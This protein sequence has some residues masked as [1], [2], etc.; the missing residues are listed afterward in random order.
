MSVPT[1][2]RIGP[3]Y[4]IL[5]MTPKIRLKF[6]GKNYLLLIFDFEELAKLDLSPGTYTA[7]GPFSWSAS[8]STRFIND[9]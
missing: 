4:T 7:T 3:T 5:N 8:H 6:N 1:D 2:L 9:H